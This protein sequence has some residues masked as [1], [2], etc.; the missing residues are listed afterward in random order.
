M[1]KD[2]INACIV[3]AVGIAALL[4]ASACGDEAGGTYCCTF[5][6]RHS[7]CGG[8]DYTT[9]ETKYYEFDLDDY[10]EGWSPQRVC[11]KFSGND[12]ECSATCC[13]YTEAR[14]NVVSGGSCPG[15]SI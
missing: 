8:G 10:V 12:T 3:G 9:W 15:E 13:I 11:D 1:A 6:S 14:N 5:E 7:A 4:L 2:R